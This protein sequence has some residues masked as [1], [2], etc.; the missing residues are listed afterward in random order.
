MDFVRG[1]CL[2]ALAFLASISAGTLGGEMQPPMPSSAA[3]PEWR[4]LLG[5]GRR[6]IQDKKYKEAYEVLRKA[7]EEKPEDL[8]VNL[9]LGRAA[10]ETGDYKTAVMAFERFLVVKPDARRV[11]LDLARSH[12]MLGNFNQARREFE[13]VLATEPP[14]AVQTNIRSF[15]NRMDQAERRHFISGSIKVTTGWDSNP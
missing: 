5:E 15:L 12:Y 6:L 1:K 13:A 3:Q 9:Y 4:I 2:C 14:K 8:D 7:H 10:L 11:R